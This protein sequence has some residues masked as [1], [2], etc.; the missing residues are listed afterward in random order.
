MKLKIVNIPK[1]IISFSILFFIIISII[2]VSNNS[3]SHEKPEYEEIY[4]TAG[5]TLWTISQKQNHNKYYEGK[6]IR[7][8]ISD[9]KKVNHLSNSSLSIGQKLLIP[10]I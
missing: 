3:F 8:I 2:F 7:Y 4:I 1:F 9:L 6:D 10:T 5:D